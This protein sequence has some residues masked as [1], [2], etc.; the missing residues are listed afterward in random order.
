[1]G[2]NKL[3][4]SKGFKQFMSKLYGWGA[5]V[6]IIGALFKIN[7]YPGASELLIVGLGTEALIFFF[8][9]FEP[10]H[11]EPDWSLVYP[12]LGGLYH[13]DELDGENK[14]KKLDKKSGTLTQELDKMLEDAKIGPALIESL[15]K[16]L[17]NLSETASKLTDVSNAAVATEEYVTNVKQASSSV[18][19]LSQAFKKSSDVI[20]KDAVASEDFLNNVKKA[21]ESVNNLSG[22]YDQVAQSLGKDVSATDEYV[23]SLKNAA[24]SVNKLT[25]TYTQSSENLAK[26]AK[27]IDFSAIDGASYSEQLQKISRNLEALNGVYEMH[28]K[29]TNEQLN[30]TAEVTNSIDKFLGGLNE[31]INNTEKYKNE[32]NTLT[33]QIAALNKV[34]GGML[35]AMNVTNVAS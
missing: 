18:N 33:K 7:H 11:V 30:K 35:S 5:S 29:G 2:I 23:N 19:D 6:V 21:S 1:M 31:S 13:N 25:E 24:S 14:K 9:A 15:G 10:P 28:L 20:N 3:V 32:I 8:S 17:H 26:S 4:R 34:Y 27:A 16:G 22:K 12:E